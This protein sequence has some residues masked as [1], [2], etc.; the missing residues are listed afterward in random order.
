MKALPALAD[1]LSQAVFSYAEQ[2]EDRVMV[3]AQLAEALLAVLLKSGLHRDRR[4]ERPP[5]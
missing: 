3:R 2:A 1:R 4:F 5:D